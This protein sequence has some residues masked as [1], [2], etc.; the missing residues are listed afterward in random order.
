MT[1]FSRPSPPFTTP[2]APNSG[3]RISFRQPVTEAG[4]VDAGWWPRSRDLTVELPPLLDV[5]WTACRDVTRVSYNVASC[6][7]AP[8]RL[9]WKGALCDSADSADRTRC[10]SR[11]STSQAVNT[12]TCWSYRPEAAADFAQRAL[13][14]AGGVGG[15]ER[16][17]RILELAAAPSRTRVL[18][19]C[20]IGTDV[21]ASET[22]GGPTL[23][24][25]L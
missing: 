22:A 21:D 14:L 6:E 18:P 5:L 25:S 13:D 16:P 3:V 10:C 20:S 11:S 4:F 12:S 1:V 2:P 24:D 9:Q 8:R 15:I 19:T 7:P 23:I 17:G